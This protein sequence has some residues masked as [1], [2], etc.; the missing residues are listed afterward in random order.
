MIHTKLII[1]L[2]SSRILMLLNFLSNGR[3]FSPWFNME[4]R[5]NQG[6]VKKKGT[7]ARFTDLYTALLFSYGNYCIIEFRQ[8]QFL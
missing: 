4:T 5:L 2:S 1:L 6:N 3:L 7:G 8:A